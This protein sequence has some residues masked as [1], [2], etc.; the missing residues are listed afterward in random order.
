VS[1]QALAISPQDPIAS[2]LL[3]QALQ[4]SSEVTFN[5]IVLATNGGISIQDDDDVDAIIENRASARDNALSESDSS[6][7]APPTINTPTNNN[8]NNNNNDD[9]GDD[10]DRRR[11]RNDLSNAGGGGAG[12]MRR[13]LGD[14]TGRYM[15]STPG[16]G[17]GN[18][19][20]SLGTPTSVRGGG[21][22][23]GVI[24]EEEEEESMMEVS[25]DDL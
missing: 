25:D 4:Q 5:P 12:R 2:E 7:I 3:E 14:V 19:A 10:Q 24:D 18:N 21:G 20:S 16:R 13:Q 15:Q 23:A 17:T 6:S 22:S 11:G 9:Y 8:N 1:H